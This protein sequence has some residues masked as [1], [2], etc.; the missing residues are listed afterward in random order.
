MG[1]HRH[2]KFNARDKLL[3]EQVTI[4]GGGNEVG[5]EWLRCDAPNGL[6][7]TMYQ[8]RRFTNHTEEAE[9]TRLSYGSNKLRSAYTAHAGQHDRMLAAEQHASLCPQRNVHGRP[10]SFVR[11]C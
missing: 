7:L 2:A 3:F 11:G 10:W 9:P 6:D 4:G 1:Y 8:A 5:P